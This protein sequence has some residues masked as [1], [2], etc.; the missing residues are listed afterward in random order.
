M[1]DT[2]NLEVKYKQNEC[3]VASLRLAPVQV[4]LCSLLPDCTGVASSALAATLGDE[5]G[6]NFSGNLL[7]KLG[8]A[9]NVESRDNNKQSCLST[10]RVWE[11][12]GNNHPTEMDVV[13]VYLRSCRGWRRRRRRRVG[14][15]EIIW[16]DVFWSW[17]RQMWRRNRAKLVTR[18]WSLD[19]FCQCAGKQ[20]TSE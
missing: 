11:K 4:Q 2:G 5:F 16:R 6:R 12:C 15:H 7:P 3:S 9:S 17:I 20:R 14:G 18:V 10:T 19:G 13:L 8:I 1:L